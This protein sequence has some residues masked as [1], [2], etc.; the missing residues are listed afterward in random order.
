MA[1]TT[2]RKV[3]EQSSDTQ[4]SL[5]PKDRTIA[6]I[7][8]HA[9]DLRKD[10]KF[11]QEAPPETKQEVEAAR[12]KAYDLYQERATRAEWA[13]VAQTIGRAV[14]Q[15]GAAQQGMSTGRDM[16]GLNFGPGVDWEKRIDRY[17]KDYERQV[18]AAEANAAAARQTWADKES[19]RRQGLSE[20]LK[21]LEEELKTASQ[22]EKDAADLQRQE[23][24]NKSAIE[25]VQEQNRARD[26]RE[27][28]EQKFRAGESALNRQLRRDLAE[29]AQKDT[30]SREDKFSVQ[31][32]LRVDNAQLKSLEQALREAEKKQKAAA[33]LYTDMVGADKLGKKARE[34]LTSSFGKRTGEAGVD[35]A[36]LEQIEAETS[37]D[38]S[39]LGIPL[40]KSR[41]E[42]KY[43]EKLK[44]ALVDK[45][46][47]E[48]A[49]LKKEI[50]ALMERRRQAIPGGVARSTSVSSSTK[51]SGGQSAQVPAPQAAAPQPS[52]KVKVQFKGRTYEIPADKLQD[53]LRDGAV[54]VK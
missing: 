50:A 32:Q 51:E 7:L 28:A 9:N 54:Q 11:Q 24:R 20:A 17:G 47:E 19:M 39:F 14:A 12:Q 10:P 1:E 35:P 3:Q 53:A 52:G 22:R 45:P 4:S 21:P 25:K 13:D 16:S 27:A 44:T 48:A 33:G 31:E 26:A 6:E 43:K 49:A 23:L 2:I 18:G 41:D 36:T 8:K 30:P 15:F 42:A 46:A 29:R 38:N 34:K 37:T 5:P 40:G